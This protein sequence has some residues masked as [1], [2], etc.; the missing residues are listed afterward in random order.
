MGFLLTIKSETVKEGKGGENLMAKKILIAAT[1]LLAL[2]MLI[3]QGFACVGPIFP[4]YCPR[5]IPPIVSTRWLS[6]NLNRRNLVVLDVRSPD[7]YSEGHILG[8]INVPEGEWYVND[9]FTV[10]VSI[11]WMEMPDKEELFNLIGG[12][13]ITKNSLVVVV[14][15]TSGPLS[16]APLA[17]YAVAGTTRVAI[18]LLYAGVKNV[19]ILDGGYEKWVADGYPTETGTVTPTPVIYRG[20]VDKSMVVS[21]A[22]VEKK[23]GKSIIVDARDP[24]VY[25]CGVQEPWTTEKGHIPTAKN[26]PTPSLWKITYENS[27]YARYITYKDVFTLK[28][29]TE[30]VV[31]KAKGKEIIVYCGVGGYASTAYFV[32]SEVLGYSNV[33][34]YDGSAQEWTHAGKPVECP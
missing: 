20:K 17:L 26:L 11:P 13:G 22:Y 8:A 29:M 25:N 9:P 2:S 7:A 32:L 19:A 31:G 1:A 27:T 15:S 34:L 3:S 16:P 4:C 18:T 30:E 12:A 33:R 23:I 21:M 6:A 10:D 14:G 28:R 5:H 24:E